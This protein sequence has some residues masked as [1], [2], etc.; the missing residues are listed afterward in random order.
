[1]GSFRVKNY[2]FLKKNFQTLKAIEMLEKP[3]KVIQ[4]ITCNPHSSDLKW[5]SI[6]C[7]T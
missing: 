6:C 4:Y 2:D 3:K 5:C 1:M 7:K